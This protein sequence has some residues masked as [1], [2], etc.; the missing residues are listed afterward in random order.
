MAS[1]IFLNNFI[2]FNEYAS[3]LERIIASAIEN[4]VALSPCGQP[5]RSLKPPKPKWID[6]GGLGPNITNNKLNI[7]IIN[8]ENHYTWRAQ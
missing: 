5:K 4:S 3:I 6:M 2:I 8:Y 7:L 1:V